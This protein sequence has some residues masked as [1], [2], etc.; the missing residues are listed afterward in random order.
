MIVACVE[1]LTDHLD[2]LKSH[3]P[4]HFEELALDRQTVPLDPQYGEYLRRDAA[5]MVLF[6][7]LRKAGKIIGY[8][9]GFVAP[10]LHYQT[11][12]TLTTDIFYLDPEHRNGNPGPALKL[13][14]EVE[15]EARRRGVNRW[16]VGCKL[17]RDASRLFAH[18]GF[19]AVEIHH[20]KLLEPMHDH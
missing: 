17:H 14:R 4:I 1:R 12:L 16:F 18:L 20:S 9:V 15:R 19:E 5:G 8:Y 3:F 11:C 7:A 13:F 6:V 10:G 2:E